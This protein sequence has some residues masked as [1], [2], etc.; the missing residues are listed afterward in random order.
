MCFRKTAAVLFVALAFA[1][2]G[3]GTSPTYFPD[4][5]IQVDDDKLFDAGKATPAA[6][7]NSYDFAENTFMKPGDRSDIKAVNVNT[8]DEDAG[9]CRLQSSSAAQTADRRRR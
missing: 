4:D 9:P 8:I 1:T 5:P 2:T 7:S 6:S 3:R